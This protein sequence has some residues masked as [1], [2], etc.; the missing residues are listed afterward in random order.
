M[1]NPVNTGCTT[2]TG[3]FFMSSV[4]FLKSEKHK[5]IYVT[6]YDVTIK[7][8]KRCL[9]LGISWFLSI[10]NKLFPEVTYLKIGGIML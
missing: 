6:V 7:I 9:H 2:F 1:F 8:D 4:S 10:C 3:L 5:V